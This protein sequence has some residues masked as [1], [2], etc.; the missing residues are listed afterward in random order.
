MPP[1]HHPL[2]TPNKQSPFSSNPARIP[3]H[4]PLECTSPR[5]RSV[6]RWDIVGLGYAYEE[7]DDADDTD[8][9]VELWRYMWRETI[10]RCQR[11]V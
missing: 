3:P 2:N 10:H 8:G 4:H 7:L 1:S 11:I 6:H 9:G 5:A